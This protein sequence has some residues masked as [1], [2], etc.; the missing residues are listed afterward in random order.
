MT[1]AVLISNA[2]SDH[3]MSFEIKH[4]IKQNFWLKLGKS[5]AY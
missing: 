2:I 4:A 3:E 5:Y 1:I